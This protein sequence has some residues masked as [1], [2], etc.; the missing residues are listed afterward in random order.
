MQ[1]VFSAA[2]SKIL[3]ASSV[4]SKLAK[5]KLNPQVALFCICIPFFFIKNVILTR[6]L[7]TVQVSTSNNVGRWF[8]ASRAG[9]LLNLFTSRVFHRRMQHLNNRHGILRLR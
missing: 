3:R 8:E 6:L 5:T 7:F 2:I 9:F 1:P 4:I